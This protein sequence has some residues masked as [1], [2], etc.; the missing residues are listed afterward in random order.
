M[1]RKYSQAPDIN[2]KLAPERVDKE[3]S[4]HEQ[5]A[6]DDGTEKE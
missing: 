2:A 6:D 1:L 5:K 3:A 4:S